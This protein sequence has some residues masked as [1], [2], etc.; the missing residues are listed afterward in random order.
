LIADGF[1]VLSDTYYPGWQVFV[2]G[3]EAKIYQ[4][5]YLFRAVPLKQGEHVVEFRYS[6]SSFRTGLAIS[7]SCGIVLCGLVVCGVLMHR[8]PW[9]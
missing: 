4:A 9:N 6:P 8:Q 2:D 1:L 3:E 5:D 7:L